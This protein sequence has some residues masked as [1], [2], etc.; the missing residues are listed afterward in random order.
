MFKNIARAYFGDDTEKK[1]GRETRNGSNKEPMET[2][3]PE[4]ELCTVFSRAAVVMEFSS[5]ETKWVLNNVLIDTGLNA[6]SL[7]GLSIL[8]AVRTVN[9]RSIQSKMDDP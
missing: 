7:D 6:L 8:P 4:S 2:L 5:K 9:M 1:L 3:E